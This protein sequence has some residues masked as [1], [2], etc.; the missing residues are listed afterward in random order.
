MLPKNLC[1]SPFL[2]TLIIFD[3]PG[4]SPSQPK[5]RTMAY[6]A[7]ISHTLASLST[8]TV[9]EILIEYLEPSFPKVTSWL[10]EAEH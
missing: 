3:Q 5:N 6:K 8:L 2:S 1:A 10:V 7:G 4:G 9:G